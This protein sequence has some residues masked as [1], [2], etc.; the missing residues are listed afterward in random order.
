MSICNCGRSTNSGQ[1]VCDRCTAFAMFGLTRDATQ[2]EIKDAYRVLAKVWHPD[3]FPGDETLRL[4]AEEK[5]KEINSAYQLLTTPEDKSAYRASSRPAPTP[6]DFHQATA[7]DSEESSYRRPNTRPVSPPFRMRRRASRKWLAIP[8]AMLLAGGTWIALR[9]A[10]PTS[11]DFW[12]TTDTDDSATHQ[13]GSPAETSPK[14]SRTGANGQGG[15]EKPA[16]NGSAGLADKTGAHARSTAVS[17]GASLVE[18]PS[19]DPLVPYF[20]VGS[21]KDDVVRV[22]GTPDKVTGSVFSY[23]LSEVYFRNGRV[24]SWHTDPGRPLKARLPQ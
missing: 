7:S 1:T 24:D 9:Y 8:V 17:S 18:Y 12:N 2:T 3:R 10:H 15:K 20:T 4:K 14:E 22:Q 6:E 23:G 13:P 19:D 16:T 21:T 5:L 11:W